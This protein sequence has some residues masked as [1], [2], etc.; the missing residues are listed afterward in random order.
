MTALLH[1]HLEHDSRVSPL[2]RWCIVI[3]TVSLSFLLGLL[4]QNGV[5]TVKVGGL[6]LVC[7]LVTACQ[8]DSRCFLSHSSLGQCGFNCARP[9]LMYEISTTESSK[10]HRLSPFD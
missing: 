4:E 10:E 7:K 3:L 2:P 9:H 6:V 8:C 1:G 5:V